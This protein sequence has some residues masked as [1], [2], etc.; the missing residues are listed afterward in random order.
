MTKLMSPCGSLSELAVQAMRP[1]AAIASAPMHLVAAIELPGTRLLEHAHRVIAFLG[2]EELFR[3]GAADQLGEA[4]SAHRLAGAIEAHD[5]SR[6]VEHE[7]ERVDRIEN[8]GDEVAL[9]CGARSMRWRE[10]TTRSCWLVLV[11][12]LQACDD[13]ARQNFQRAPCSRVNMFG[14]GEHTAIVPSTEL[15]GAKIGAAA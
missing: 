2:R 14:S 9:D 1:H 12:E 13:L 5:A 10:R 11:V 3:E 4:E 7:H 8:R 15:F 6:G